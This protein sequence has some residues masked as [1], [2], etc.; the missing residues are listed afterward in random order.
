MC[1]RRW[2]SRS[3][4]S[5]GHRHVLLSKCCAACCPTFFFFPVVRGPAVAELFEAL[6]GS[7]N[8]GH[9]GTSGRAFAH[10]PK[11]KG[12]RRG[13]VG[14]GP[15]KDC[16]GACFCSIMWMLCFAAFGEQGSGLGSRMVCGGGGGHAH[17]RLWVVAPHSASCMSVCSWSRLLRED[18]EGGGWRMLRVSWGCVL[19]AR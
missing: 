17:T 15:L 5:S 3:R 10:T 18:V 13:K 4:A 8:Q 7:D 14:W 9:P 2:L 12:S 19:P 16:E 6:Y 1:I 11:S